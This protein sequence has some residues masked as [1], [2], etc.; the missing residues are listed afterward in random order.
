MNRQIESFIER[1]NES[2]TQGNFEEIKMLLDENVV[3]VTPDLKT[4]IIGKSGCIR[5]IEDYANNAN[6]D[7]FKVTDKRIH[8]WD[9][10][11][12]VSIDYYI[13]YETNNARYK[14]IGSEFWT[15]IEHR[16]SWK[17]VWRAMVRNERVK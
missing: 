5:T 6:T 3:F 2:W 1:F 15:L 13:E 9:S 11:A 4:E 7:V 16:N 12:M 14:E 17:L 8:T 10:T